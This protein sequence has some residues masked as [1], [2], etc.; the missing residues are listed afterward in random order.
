M[1]KRTHTVSREKWHF[2]SVDMLPDYQDEQHEPDTQNKD[3]YARRRH[4]IDAND[5]D[6]F[7]KLIKHMYVD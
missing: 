3:R 1:G 5:I 4:A 6:D 2:V 7:D